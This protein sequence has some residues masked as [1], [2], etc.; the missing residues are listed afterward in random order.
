VQACASRRLQ[1]HFAGLSSRFLTMA[2]D[3]T[4]HR[5]FLDKILGD[6]LPDETSTRGWAVASASK[7]DPHHPRRVVLNAFK[8][9]AI[10][11]R[12]LKATTSTIDP[13]FPIGRA[14]LRSPRLACLRRSRNESC[15][16]A[17]SAISALI[18]MIG[19]LDSGRP[20]SRC[21]RPCCCLQ[22]GWAGMDRLRQSG[23]AT[24][25][26]RLTYL[27]A[28]LVRFRVVR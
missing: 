10:S 1:Y 28:R 4:C 22:S 25:N 19:T 9:R 5:R 20:C 21:C 16:M 15:P 17:L 14:T 26:M 8:R 18:D 6:R 12:R 3:G 2:V 11:A 24:F 27:L 23:D 7:D 13:T